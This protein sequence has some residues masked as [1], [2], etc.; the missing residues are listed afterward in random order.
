MEILRIVITGGVGAGKSSLIRTISEIDVVDTDKEATDELA[1]IKDKTTVAMDFGRIT[2]AAN[3]SLHLY[4]TPGQ[5]RFDFMWDILIRKAQ[6][7]ILLV[8]A[9]RPD[10]F[11]YARKIVKFMN[12]RVQIPYLIGV[13]HTDC[14]DAWE[15]EDV[16]LAL[17]FVDETTRPPL[18]AVNAT[19][20]ASVKEALMAIVLEL[21]KSC[22]HQL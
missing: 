5:T 6:A 3:Q 13:T 20:T 19:E 2:I 18:I 12:E 11:R 15:L 14:A 16:A 17:G 8:A 1:E 10:H 21:A 22:Q 4:G 7:Y 9:H